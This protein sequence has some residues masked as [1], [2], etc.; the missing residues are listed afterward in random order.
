[1][2]KGLFKI[3]EKKIGRVPK[4]R[5]GKSEIIKFYI[6]GFKSNSKRFTIFINF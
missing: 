6:Y 4:K 3:S 5:V 2:F 1:M